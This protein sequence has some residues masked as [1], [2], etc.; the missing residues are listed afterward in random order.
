MGSSKAARGADDGVMEAERQVLS[1]TEQEP[2]QHCVAG[3]RVVLKTARTGILTVS[4]TCIK[5]DPE[6][7]VIGSCS[8]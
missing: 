4:R 2:D 8:G 6:L 3:L 7:G 1:S 5:I